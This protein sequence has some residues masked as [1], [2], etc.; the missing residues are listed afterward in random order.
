MCPPWTTI[1]AAYQL[2]YTAHA[3][4][5]VLFGQSTAD[6]L[7]NWVH[8]V[9]FVLKIFKRT[10]RPILVRKLFT[11]MFSAPSIL[12]ANEFNPRFPRTLNCYVTMTLH[13]F[14]H[15]ISCTVGLL[16]FI[17]PHYK[18]MKIFARNLHMLLRIDYISTCVIHFKCTLLLEVIISWQVGG[19][20]FYGPFCI[21][22]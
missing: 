18:F 9:N 6:L 3:R 15:C 17:L 5:S 14:P 22:N 19:R 11:D 20:F 12:L 4:Y 13:C 2:P 8:L 7:R 16:S 1:L 21:I 10:E